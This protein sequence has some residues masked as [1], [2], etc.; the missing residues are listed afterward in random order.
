MH[1]RLNSIVVLTIKQ[2][3]FNYW[4]GQRA[5]QMWR[6]HVRNKKTEVAPVI[7]Q[8][9]PNST[10]KGGP[11]YCKKR[12]SRKALDVNELSPPNSQSEFK[13]SHKGRKNKH[14]RDIN[15]IFNLITKL[16]LLSDPA[17]DALQLYSNWT[18][19]RWQLRYGLR[20]RE[21]SQCR[22]QR[23]GDSICLLLVS[24][25]WLIPFYSS[26]MLWKVILV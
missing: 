23:G 3:H 22:Y 18:A 19:W 6:F 7:N 15:I 14:R 16:C 12:W 8:L 10:F 5:E 24:P 21:W 2:I 17:C 26:A 4:I 25:L 13:P 20:E 11:P 1:A 9:A